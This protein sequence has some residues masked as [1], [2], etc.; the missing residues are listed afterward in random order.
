MK[1]V[2]KNEKYSEN[3]SMWM[4]QFDI[5]LKMNVIYYISI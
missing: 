3:I 4:I 1:S 5:L 2:V